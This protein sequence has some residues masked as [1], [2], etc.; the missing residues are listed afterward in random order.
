MTQIIWYTR[1]LALA[2]ALIALAL[3]PGAG[4]Q[5]AA[6]AAPA[7]HTA[8]D[9]VQEKTLVDMAAAND[10]QSLF[11]GEERGNWCGGGHGGFNDCCNGRPCSACNS[12]TLSSQCL[13]QCPPVSSLDRVCAHHDA[14]YF[15]YRQRGIGGCGK[16]VG[17]DYYCDCDAHLINGMNSLMDHLGFSDKAYAHAAIQWFSNGKCRCPANSGCTDFSR[18]R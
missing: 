8:A 17:S 3:A 4:A 1:A 14:C 12:P 16:V 18:C 10:P 5:D 11:W 15:S 13:Q 2:C 6:L 9:E 7:P